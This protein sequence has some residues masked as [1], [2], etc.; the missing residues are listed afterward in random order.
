M[1]A[2]HR[3]SALLKRARALHAKGRHGEARELEAQ[4]ARL[5]KTLDR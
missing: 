1:S 2:I 3:A 5:W 4:A